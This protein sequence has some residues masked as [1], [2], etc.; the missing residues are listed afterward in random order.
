M[1]RRKSFFNNEMEQ[2]F[3]LRKYT[4]GL[5][6]VCLGLITLGMG[7][8]TV[9]ADAINGAEESSVVQEN[10]TQDTTPANNA[11][12]AETKTNTSD[13][14][15]VKPNNT[16]L[17][18]TKQ[19][20]AGSA[21][22]KP[23]T[24]DSATLTVVKPSETKFAKPVA[25]KVF[26]E[27][28]VATNN[29]FNPANSR[30]VDV[31]EIAESKVEKNYN[32]DINAWTGHDDGTYYVLDNYTPQNNAEKDLIVIPNAADFEKAGK[33]INGH[34]VGITRD[35][36]LNFMSTIN[37]KE[38]HFSETDGKKIK[39]IGYDWHSAF[40]RADNTNPF[41]NSRLEAM[42]GN[43]LD[44]SSIVD[45][46]WMFYNDEQLT[47]ISALSTWDVSNT[48]Q[49][50]AFFQDTDISDLTPFV[51]W[52]TRSLKY[53]GHGFSYLPHL[54]SIEPL[55]HWNMKNARFTD[56]MFTQ[57]PELIDIDAINDWDYSNEV[58]TG[59]EWGNYPLDDMFYGDHKIKINI[60]ID[61]RLADFIR[62]TGR[63]DAFHNSSNQITTSNTKLI[64]LL[65][66]DDLQDETS[67]AKR[68]ITFTDLPAG[69]G[70]APIIQTVHYTKL[71]TATIDMTATSDSNAY[72][73]IVSLDFDKDWKLDTSKQNDAI[74]V[75][76][77]I[78]FKSVKIPHINGYTAHLVRNKIN[79]ALFTVSFMA[80]P[81]EN[82]PSTPVEVAPSKPSAPT[83]NSSNSAWNNL[84][85]KIVDTLNQSNSGWTILVDKSTHKAD[86]SVNAVAIA[87]PIHAQTRVQTRA[88]KHFKLR[89]HGKKHV[90][91]H[92]KHRK[93]VTKHG[94]QHIAKHFKYRK[95]A[96]KHGKKHAIMHFKHRKK[97]TSRFKKHRL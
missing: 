29:Q 79:P 65:T 7:S 6:S 50:T 83:V 69:K 97:A 2:R 88:N 62:R 73:K 8:Q 41:S 55:R 53:I 75:N 18:D 46:N 64:K 78:H 92:L 11:V 68:T 89:K 37:P 17:T 1:Q 80:V 31:K 57:D 63:L 77:Q 81:S 86:A 82:K 5:C 12:S 24:A 38:V 74:I 35:V 44:T 66:N 54:T 59:G 67:I 19:N 95:K 39:A 93:K 3:S 58:A 47:N 43:S 25:A 96:A 28:K 52:N 48:V 14:V 56:N 21:V 84:D 85:H 9:K 32:A 15:A 13:S 22:V 4:I 34:E 10:K 42:T 61:S 72:G 30:A 20:K 94:K 91:K 26:A 71:A 49:M 76:G 36:T 27:S 23:N 90:V 70:L 51:N 16:A 87:Q 60:G 33:N 40:R 45:M